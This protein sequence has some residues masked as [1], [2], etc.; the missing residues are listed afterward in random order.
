MSVGLAD[1]LSDLADC[2]RREW[3][4]RLGR[5][6]V[7]DSGVANS[8]GRAL[9]DLRSPR[10]VKANSVKCVIPTEWRCRFSYRTMVR[11]GLLGS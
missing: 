8:S 1:G 6:L 10:Q 7:V 11:E 3:V 2:G 9:G 4:L 5:A